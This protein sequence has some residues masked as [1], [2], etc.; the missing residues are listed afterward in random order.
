MPWGSAQNTLSRPPIPGQP[1]PM[2]LS[3]G[4]LSTHP[5]MNLFFSLLYKKVAKNYEINRFPN[6]FLLTNDL[7]KFLIINKFQY[8]V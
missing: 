7:S 1:G 2:K 3:H 5:G 6:I 8:F 4:D